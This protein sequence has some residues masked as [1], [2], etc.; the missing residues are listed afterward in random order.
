MQILLYSHP[1]WPAVGGVETATL[2]LA[3]GMAA[4]GHTITV[5]TDTPSDSG[6]DSLQ[7][8]RILRRPGF[9]TVLREMRRA[10]VIHM[11][12][13]SLLPLFCGLFVRTPIVVELHGYQAICPQG[14]F[15]YGEG[16]CP[17]H[18]RQGRLWKC[19]RCKADDKGRGK[20]LASLLLQVPRYALCRAV[21]A[22]FI[23]IT[24]HVA[25]R[26]GFP[27]SQTIY[28][29]IKPINA[30][31]NGTNEVV[32]AYVGRFV[33]EKGLMLLVRAARRLFDLGYSFRLR[34][35]GDGPQRAALQTLADELG[36]ESVFSITGFLH[37]K[38]LA[39]ATADITAVVMPSIWEE[40]AGL[41]AIEQMMR[42]GVVI[43]ANI[44]G[45]GE[46]VGTGGILFEPGDEASLVA[47]MRRVLDFP[48]LA[49]EYGARASERA[50]LLFTADRMVR[51]HLD[52]YRSILDAS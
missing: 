30:N 46:V 34:L 47:A 20:A 48:A 49:A 45:L 14:L 15:L 17:G 52:L 11:A 40:T 32:F 5:I 18:F 42:G 1:F 31:R 29:G 8:F 6:P 24:D 22:R 26:H 36:L 27:R 44:G 21:P 7:K 41:S 13:P 35:V 4:A 39:D 19:F 10:E 51:E 3:N 25:L 43:A 37:G 16:P 9:R 33:R 28:Y 50:R 12:G 2:L 23:S 38:D